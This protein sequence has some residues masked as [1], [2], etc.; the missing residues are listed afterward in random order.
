MINFRVICLLLDSSLGGGEARDGH[1]E[2]RARCVVH[3]NLST[4]LHR[5]GLTTMLTTDTAAEVRTNLT[6][7]L[8]SILDETAYTLLVG[9][10]GTWYLSYT[11]S[12]FLFLLKMYQSPLF[13]PLST[14]FLLTEESVFDEK[15]N[16]ISSSV[17]LS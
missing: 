4:E 6:T 12:I 14:L 11:G 17:L 15:K 5:A 10:T 9:M 13:P 2:G 7:F 16:I 1:T 3:A 8:H